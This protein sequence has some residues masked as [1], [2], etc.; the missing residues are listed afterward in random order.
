MLQGLAL[1]VSSVPA[2]QR[3]RGEAVQENAQQDGQPYDREGPF[4]PGKSYFADCYEHVTG[5]K[6]SR[7]GQTTR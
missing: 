4:V 5:P 2:G 6:Q 3:N 7:A 1:Q